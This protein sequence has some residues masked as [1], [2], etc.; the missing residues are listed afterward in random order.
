MQFFLQGLTMGLAYVAPIGM[1]NLFVI[2]AALTSSRR[3]ALATAFIVLFFDV[4]LSLACF[5]GV[6][7]VINSH[8]WLQAGI[9]GIGSIIVIA[10]GVG[11]IRT[12]QTALGQMDQ[13]SLGKTISKA[14]VVTWFNP[15]AILDGTMMLGAFRVTLSTNQATP[16]MAG[17]ISASFV[18]FLGLTT[19]ISL[20]SRRFSP[21]TLRFINI[22]CGAVIVFYGVKLFCNF[23]QL[24]GLL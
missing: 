7:A 14:C 13:L 9:L 20:Y 17:V 21:K 11:L 16:F 12:R 1:Q 4:T 22:V 2:N 19:F 18:W 10:I 15:Q 8:E 24:T 6:G 5:Y 3:R 23:L